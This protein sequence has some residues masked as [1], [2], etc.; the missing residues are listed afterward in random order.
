MSVVPPAPSAHNLTD[1]DR[2]SL[3][4]NYVGSHRR[5]YRVHLPPH[6]RAD[7]DYPL[8]MVLHGCRQDHLEIEK[9]SQFDA[10]ADKNNFIVVYPFVTQYG[11]L[12]ARNCWGWWRPQHVRPGS[13]EV[14]DLWQIVELVCDEF[15]I[16]RRRIYIAGLSSGAG[17]TVAALTVHRGRFAAGAAVAGVAYA[18]TPRAAIAM[19]FSN[20][21]VYRP[22]A[23]T[24]ASMHAVREGDPALPPLLIVH[25][26]DDQTV[27]I[28][29]AENLRDAWLGYLFTGQAPLKRCAGSQTTGDVQWSHM[30]Y[31]KLLRPAVVETFFLH[32]PG[33]GWYGGAPGDFSFP[34]APDVSQLIWQ[35]FKRRKLPGTSK[36]PLYSAFK[37]PASAAEQYSG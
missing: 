17:M 22:T 12:R 27:P 25:S 35:F 33:H 34:D 6:Y 15:S 36:L 30:R 24:I 37:W 20:K 19:P 10:I 26:H 13:G 32:G 4:G 8:V 21:R 31:G 14:E 23:D 2:E 7:K 3:P 9:I 16:N 29:A 1:I 11:D 18:E 28:K 5:H